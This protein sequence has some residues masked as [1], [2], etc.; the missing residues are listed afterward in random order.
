MGRKGRRI[1]WV[2]G[3]AVRSFGHLRWP[4]DDRVTLL[5][6]SLVVA[7]GD[8]GVDLG[9]TAGWDVA[10]GDGDGG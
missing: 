4:Q 10:G 6:P 2:E 5:A 8:Q 9:G 1:M 7:E 3:M